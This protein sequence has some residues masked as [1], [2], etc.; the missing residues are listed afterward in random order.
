MNRETRIAQC[1]T[2][3]QRGALAA[4]LA[5]P[6]LSPRVRE[7]AEMVKAAALGQGIATISGWSGRTA[8]TVRWWLGRYLTDGVEALG[9]A[10]RAGRPVRADAAY[11]QALETA[12]STPP[13]DLGLLFDVWTSA[14][15]ATY[16]AETTGVRLSPDWLRQVIAQQRIR[17]GRP[18][19]TL[20]HLQDAEA[21]AACVAE[22]AEVGEK[23][24]GRARAL[25]AAS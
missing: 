24:G 7:R 21:V 2:A 3:E 23:G 4:L 22:L 20:K 6:D 5:R 8:E 9:D 13:R 19:H 16:L 10:P 1:L 14:R 18:K 25:R 11:R 17:A 12:L 15:L